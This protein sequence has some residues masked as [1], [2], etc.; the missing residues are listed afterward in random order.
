MEQKTQRHPLLTTAAIC[1]FVLLLLLPQRQKVPEDGWQEQNGNVSYYRDGAALT[2]WQEIDGNLYYLGTDGTLHT[3]WQE[4]G[5]NT[6]YLGADGA[7]RTGWLDTGSRRYY[8]GTDGAVRTGWQNI[9]GTDYYFLHDGSLA[10]GLV[11]ENGQL[12]LFGEQGLVRSGWIQLDGKNYYGDEAGHPVTGW[13]QIGGKSHYFEASGAAASGWKQMDGFT[14]YFHSDGSP[15]QGEEIIGGKTYHFA[16]NGQMVTLVNPWHML[17]EGYAVELV[18]IS[19]THLIAEIAYQDYMDMMA[20]CTAAGFKPAV[21]SAYR[22][23]EYQEK[24]YQNRI[25]RYIWAGKSEE[26]ATELAGQSVAVPGTSEHQLG[27]A[28]D[29]VDDDNCKLDESQ[30]KM[31]TQ[32]WLMENSWRYGWILRYPNEKSEI[33][34]IIYE[35]W[36]YRYVGK[37]VAKEIYESGLCLEEYLQMLTNSVG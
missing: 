16:S 13:V 24:L 32:K 21:C 31:P 28:L 3:D 17:P 14:H 12:Y 20:D 18:P 35:P 29:I 5:G 25:Q 33:T 30:A 2:G 23:H 11:E 15:A 22:T 27:L 7:M 4:I 36:H 10:S 19:D 6:Y 8:L 1:L 37:T 9:Y 26:E 34:G